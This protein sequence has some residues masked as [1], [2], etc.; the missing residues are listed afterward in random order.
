MANPERESTARLA[1]RPHR[2]A[3]PNQAGLL[4]CRVARAAMAR[5]RLG[6]GLCRACSPGRPKLD[7]SGLSC[8]LRR[9]AAGWE[10]QLVD[11]HVH[12]R[13]QCVQN[14]LCNG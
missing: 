1:T 5:P 4:T 13:E 14:T 12:V 7:W 11:W 3:P 8:P 9:L 6:P 2:L 10:Q